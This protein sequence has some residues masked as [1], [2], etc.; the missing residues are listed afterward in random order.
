[1]LAHAVARKFGLLFLLFGSISWSFVHAQTTAPASNP[2]DK[3]FVVIQEK[4][5]F[6]VQSKVIG[7]AKEGTII[8]VDAINGDWLWVSSAK[9]YLPKTA[10]LPIRNAIQVYTD[11]IAKK[12]EA[13]NYLQRGQLYRA[14]GDQEKSMQDV[15]AGL[16]ASPGNI[17]LLLMKGIVLLDRKE[18][19]SA[20]QAFNKC[21]GA[22][23]AVKTPG[24]L[25]DVSLDGKTIMVNSK[26]LALNNR[27]WAHSEKGDFATAVSDFDRA[28]LIDP[29]YLR[30]S[31][32]RALTLERQGQVDQAIE[33][34]QEIL[35]VLPKHARTI[36]NR[37]RAYF[38]KG[39]LQKAIADFDE[40]IKIDP[41]LTVAFA[42]RRSV[43]QKQ[44][45][46][47]K[48]L[49]NLSHWRRYRS[50]LSIRSTVWHGFLPRVRITPF[51]MAS[52]P[53]SWL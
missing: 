5:D 20:I 9:A 26:V 46:W 7:T 18:Y 6:Q 8:Q 32:N 27:G 3:R 4:A 15:E 29:N 14:I 49:M 38:V 36:N 47:K 35:K 40:A 19:E 39:D 31:L 43:W 30:A 22:I 2:E 25:S 42:N 41:L 37:G 1:M 10:A 11:R 13:N 48:S 44:K 12:P 16:N 34:Y 23:D 33:G 28:L 51:V 52:E 24:V 21:I 53:N 45:D 17:E 50:P